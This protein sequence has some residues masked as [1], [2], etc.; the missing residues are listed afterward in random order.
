MECIKNRFCSHFDSECS[1]LSPT[2]SGQYS[3][4]GELLDTSLR[5]RGDSSLAEKVRRGRQC[6]GCWIFWILSWTQQGDLD[7]QPK[8]PTLN[9]RVAL[10]LCRLRAFPVTVHP[11]GGDV[12]ALAACTL[13]LGRRGSPGDV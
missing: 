6:P 4:M 2:A 5:H 8:T 11:P 10:S 9:Q 7:N 13:F 12:H 3:L 1:R